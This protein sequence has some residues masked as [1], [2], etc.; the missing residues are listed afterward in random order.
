MNSNEWEL[1]KLKIGHLETLKHDL[2]LAQ[3][4][5]PLGFRDGETSNIDKKLDDLIKETSTTLIRLAGI[6]VD[7]A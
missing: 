1:L 6:E 2:H 4:K 3:N 5:L 7:T